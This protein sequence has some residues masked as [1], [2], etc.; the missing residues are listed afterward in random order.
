MIET[1]ASI[2]ERGFKPYVYV[3]P[4]LDGFRITIQALMSLNI[5]ELNGK[6]NSK[7]VTCFAT[8]FTGKIENKEGFMRQ[9]S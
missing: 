3:R 5:H 1:N 8:R 4:F 2:Q 7:Q 9:K 6:M